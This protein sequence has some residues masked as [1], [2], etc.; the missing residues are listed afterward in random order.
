M[1]PEL[2]KSPLF[3]A[4]FFIAL[5]VAVAIGFWLARSQSQRQ[6]KQMEEHHQQLNEQSEASIA[7]LQQQL[8]LSQQQATQTSNALAEQQAHA[9][10]LTTAE[11]LLRE[12]LN[13]QQIRLQQ[14]ESEQHALRQQLAHSET[15]YSTLQERHVNQTKALEEKQALLQESEQRLAKEF[16]NLANR[17]FEQKSQAFKSNSESGLESLLKPFREQ[18]SGFQQQVSKQTESDQ[19]QHTLLKKELDDLKALNLRMSEEATNLTRALK[20]DSKTQGNWGEVILQ[21]LLDQAGLTEG[22]E[23]ELQVSLKTEQG[24]R[25]QPDVIVRLPHDK[26]IVIDSKVSLTAYERFTNA[27]SDADKAV[28]LTEHVSSLRN[29][30]REL[31]KKNYQSLQGVRS[32]DYVLM[33]VPVEAAFLCAI[34]QEPELIKTALDSNIMLVSPTNLLVAL[35]TIHNIWRVEQQNQNAQEIADRAGKLYDKFV[36]FVDDLNKVDTA[37]QRASKEFDAAKGKLS[38]GPGNL[39][40]QTTMLKEL[41]VRSNK[42]LS[43]ELVDKSQNEC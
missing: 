21:R 4:I 15:Q 27:E 28:A 37:L 39:I 29:H 36:G 16:E 11:K 20:G 7:D 35:R 23:Y 1:S 3:L 8:Q 31:G 33:F 5:L 34:Q 42:Q 19:Q 14:T 30:I 40:R 38:S 6:L 9:A 32:L 10:G 25:Y 22:R 24:K 12:Q 41:G 17:I 18:I 26:D 43:A 13:T 2:L